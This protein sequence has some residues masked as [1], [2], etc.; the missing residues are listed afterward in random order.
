MNK[1]LPKKKS[2]KSPPS[3]GSTLCSSQETHPKPEPLPNNPPNTLQKLI[4]RQTCNRWFNQ[5]ILHRGARIK[6]LF[7]ILQ[8]FC[9]T[10]ELQT[11]TFVLSVHLFDAVISNLPLKQCHMMQVALVANQ[12]AT[13]V[14]ET[15]GSVLSYEDLRNNVFPIEVEEYLQ[16]EKMMLRLLEFRVN[17]VSP[18]QIL[19]FLLVEFFK[20]EYDFFP[21]KNADK[22]LKI[23]F[24]C[25]ALKLHL[26]SIVDYQFYRFT[27]LA[28]AVSIIILARRFFGLSPWTRKMFD[29]TSMAPEDVDNCVMLLYELYK[30]NFI[31]KLFTE[32]EQTG[33]DL[34]A[35]EN[36]V[37]NENCLTE[38]CVDFLLSAK[39]MS[40]FYKFD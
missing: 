2:T 28:V 14:N 10:I 16:T 40:E 4:Q 12:L 13:K 39:A 38:K 35:I 19:Q 7:G 31:E 15:Q 21:E 11:E 6:V 8:Q 23:K 25:L 37:L 5:Q 27:S 32:L 33:S 20:P 17:L 22:M 34:P 24:I 36:T 3:T 29:L 30:T 18:Y 26:I 1:L 9:N